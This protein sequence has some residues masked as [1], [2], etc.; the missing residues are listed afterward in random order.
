MTNERKESKNSRETMKS[1][2]QNLDDYDFVFFVKEEVERR[3]KKEG[4]DDYFSYNNCDTI[5]KALLKLA[6]SLED[7]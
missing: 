3:L 4:T 7:R 6:F 2:I 1:E 5:D